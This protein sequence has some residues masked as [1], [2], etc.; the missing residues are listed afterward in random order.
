MLRDKAIVALW[1]PHPQG[2]KRWP[3]GGRPASVRGLYWGVHPTPGRVC[4]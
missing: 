4:G 3:L 2:R 1:L